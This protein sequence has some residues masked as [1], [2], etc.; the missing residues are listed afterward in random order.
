M[1]LDCLVAV[2]KVV[3]LKRFQM[4]QISLEDDNFVK[5]AIGQLG[6]VSSTLILNTRVIMHQIKQI[7]V[8]YKNQT[9]KILQALTFCRT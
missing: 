4:A 8:L 1:L 3:A 9:P 5:L 2:I 6:S 7:S